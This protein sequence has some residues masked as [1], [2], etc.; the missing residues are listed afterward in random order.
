MIKTLIEG[1]FLGLST[2]SACLVTCSPIY[3][4]WLATEERNIKKSL[5]KVMEI[6]L[7]RFISYLIFGALAGYF[8]TKISPMNRELFT[9]ISYILLSV[10]LVFNAFRTS[11][12]DK[13]CLVPKWSKF[14]Q[15]AFLLGL[16]TGINFCPSFLIALSSSFELAGVSSGMLL[17][18]GFFVGTTLFLLPL[19]FTSF[20]TTMPTFKKIARYASICIALYF[21]YKGGANLFQTYH[22]W[23]YNKDNRMIELSDPKLK[24]F[25]I[26]SEAD[27][28]YS[29]A[30]KDSTMNLYNSINIEFNNKRTLSA[31]NLNELYLIEKQVTILGDTLQ[32]NIIRFDAK[33]SPS[34]LLDFLRNTNFK[35]N[36]NKRIY[37][38]M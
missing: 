8:G 18:T 16:I 30:I 6:S 12:H 5:Y 26:S 10:F 35:V 14:S 17:F 34:V 4:P 19:A 23:Q 13:K 28:L 29:K 31:R 15:S 11:S 25:V 32:T 2:G 36:K 3:L 9:G 37:W 33:S 22:Q 38:M 1:L 24:L 21:L 27:S 7:G 20:L